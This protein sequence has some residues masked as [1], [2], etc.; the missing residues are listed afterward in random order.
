MKT[1]LFGRGRHAAVL[2]AI[3]AASLVGAAPAAAAQAQP[4][5]EL[6]AK[7]VADLPTGTFAESLAIDYHGNLF[8]SDTDL[9]SSTGQIWR[10]T[11]GGA[12]TKFGPPITG[13]DAGFLS[14]LAFDDLGRLY[15]GR[16]NTSDWQ[17]FTGSIIRVGAHSASVVA[18]FPAGGSFPNGLAFH[19][20][21]LY[22]ADSIGGAIYRFRPTDQD[23]VITS[24]WFQDTLLSPEGDLG[25]NG[26]AFWGRDLFVGN[27][28]TGTIIRLPIVSGGLPGTP[29][30][31]VS[32]AS[33]VSADGLAF[34]AYGR[35][36][37]TVNYSERLML[38]TRQGTVTTMAEGFPSLDYPTQPAFGT[39]IGSLRTL[40]VTNGG[41]GSGTPTIVSYAVGVG[42][43]RLPNP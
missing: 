39:T 4:N 23:Q 19:L 33:L 12:L 38:V 35:L 17:T 21:Y 20:G 9:A 37:I 32:D 5:H 14:G 3:V 7:L 8:I 28:S 22:V 1:I 10:L 31:V 25:A 27:Y 2:F 36:W 40:Y 6:Q 30:V 43:V 16:V 41:F 15:V 42:G 24:P 11:P 18:G 13:L 34:D 26:I 29:H